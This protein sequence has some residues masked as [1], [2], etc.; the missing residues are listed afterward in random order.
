MIL[1][2]K[3]KAS[4]VFKY[5]MDRPLVEDM[6]AKVR[7]SIL[8]KNDEC[9]IKE[10]AKRFR[11]QGKVWVIKYIDDFH[12]LDVLHSMKKEAGAKIV[13]D[14]D[15][16]IWQ[17]PEGN[18]A[19]GDLKTHINRS[20]MM[21]ESV[22]AADWVTVSTEP[23]KN[24]V[25]ALN[26]NVTVLPNYLNLSDWKHKRKAGKTR[27]GWVWSPTHTPDNKE[28]EEALK[29]I[30]KKYKEVEIVIFGTDKNIF[31]FDT[32][33]IPAVPHEEYPKTFMEAG[34]DIS[35][36]PLADN[37]FNKSKS[38]IKW[39]ESTMA[40]AAFI[41]S[42]VYP[43]EFSVDHGKTGYVCKGKNQW[44]RH[45]SN[46]IEN[47]VKRKE[48]VKNAKTEVLRLNAESKQKWQS[49]YNYLKGE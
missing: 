39:L 47:P 20:L 19:R 42:K 31:D 48:L 33:N 36:A 30:N 16:N 13:V 6:G 2:I 18:I 38:N 3:H 24:A 17:I 11:K 35:I 29:E 45:I 40:G 32:V 41:G 49:F 23:L 22:K 44:V 15:D 14:L 5:R 1:C 37:D 28:V 46:L 34:I 9:T 4:A 7:L 27:I 21:C 25:Q 10:L 12:T 43:Y 8:R 26:Q